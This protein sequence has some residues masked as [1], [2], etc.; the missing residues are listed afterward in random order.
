MARIQVLELPLESV[1]SMSRTP[2]ILIIDQADPN[3][4]G[5]DPILEGLAESAGAETIMVVAHTLDVA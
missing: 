4:W 2:Y 1:G 3:E 5:Q